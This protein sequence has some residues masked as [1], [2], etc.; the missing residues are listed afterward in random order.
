M[1]MELIVHDLHA[2]AEQEIRKFAH[3][4][5][6]SGVSFPVSDVV[7]AVEQ[8]LPEWYPAPTLGTATRRDMIE[9]VVQGIL[10]GEAYEE[11]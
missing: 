9:R 2:R 8:G 1:N 3:L 10:S 7:D 4:A 6:D 11:G 5:V